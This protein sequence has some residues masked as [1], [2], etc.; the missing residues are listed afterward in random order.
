MS[1]TD[2]TVTKE[3]SKAPSKG[4]IDG[5]IDG[6]ISIPIS[7]VEEAAAITLEIPK[8]FYNVGKTIANILLP[9]EESQA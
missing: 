1:D 7:F 6:L 8:F 2:F 9:D 3:Q 5:F 4:L